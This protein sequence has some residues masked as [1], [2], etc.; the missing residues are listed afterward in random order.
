MLRTVYPL[1]CHHRGEK[2]DW[3]RR[4]KIDG[5]WHQPSR[6]NPIDMTQWYKQK[7]RQMKAGILLKE[8]LMNK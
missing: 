3:S 4:A 8:I 6:A 5:S 7:Q 1:I 2:D